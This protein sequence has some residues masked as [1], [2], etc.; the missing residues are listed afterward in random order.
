MQKGKMLQI[1]LI[2]EKNKK[3]YI[4]FIK[5]KFLVFLMIIIHFINYSQNVKENNVDV[6]KEVINWVED[7]LLNEGR[8]KI[9]ED[10]IGKPITKE[11]IKGWYNIYLIEKQSFDTVIISIFQIGVNLS[12]S[13]QNLLIQKKYK[14]KPSV[15]QIVD[16][17][18]D[19][20]NNIIKLYRFFEQYSKFSAKAKTVC[21]EKIIGDSYYFDIVNPKDEY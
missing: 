17:D 15:F 4:V 19:L 20:K 8:F 3:N 12:H 14:N 1:Q 5:R 9:M 18:I 2:Q 11:K 7:Y 13:P 10:N 21:Y 16:I 6:D